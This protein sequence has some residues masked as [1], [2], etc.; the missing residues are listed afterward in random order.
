MNSNVKSAELRAQ[1]SKQIRK[2][3]KSERFY[4][5]LNIVENIQKCAETGKEIVVE[6]FENIK[7]HYF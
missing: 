6:V 3:A 4:A 5:N 1:L 2:G 7:D